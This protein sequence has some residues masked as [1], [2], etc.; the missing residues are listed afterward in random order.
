MLKRK[1][2]QELLNWKKERKNE[3]SRN[4]I[5]IK[6]QCQ[7]GKTYIVKEFGTREYESF[8]NI[9]LKKQPPL[10]AIFDSSSEDVIKRIT[11]YMPNVRLIPGKT[12]IFIDEI[13][14]CENA[15]KSL[16]FLATDLRFDVVATGDLVAISE[17]K[18]KTAE[19]TTSDVDEFDG[20]IIG[21]V[22]TGEDYIKEITLYPLDF[23]EFLWASGFDEKSLQRLKEY[24]DSGELIPQGLHRKYENLFREYL[25]VGGMPEVVNDF[26]NYKDYA[27]VTHLQEKIIDRYYGDI[28]EKAKGKQKKLVKKCYDSIPK[29]LSSEL[30]K[31]KYSRVEK[32]QTKRKYGKSVDYL[33]KGGFAYPCYNIKE[34]G[35][36]LRQHSKE[37]QFKLY[38]NDTGLLSCMYGFSTK[39]DILNDTVKGHTRTAVYENG[40][41][42]CLVGSGYGIYYYKPDDNHEVE[43]VLEK[44]DDT[45]PIEVKTGRTVSVSLQ[46]YIDGFKPSVAYKLTGD[47]NETDGVTK[48]LPHYAI[49]FI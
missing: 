42:Q 5:L 47:R 31:F 37:N 2:Y 8:V 33:T 17:L 24:M 7:V 39:R 35:T 13:D 30:K 9:N 44:E 23:E 15:I 45:F 4:C 38:L 34:P 22:H 32:G 41:A 19:L 43:F 3:L 18:E 6:G 10:K 49:L 12:L 21:R 40:I 46:S 26:T 28:E 11:A 36:P 27:R 14:L 48:M 29:Q 1:A 20:R 25:V 16:K